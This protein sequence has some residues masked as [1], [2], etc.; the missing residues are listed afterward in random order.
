M[1]YLKVKQAPCVI[2]DSFIADNDVF[3]LFDT[4]INI[5]FLDAFIDNITKF[6][7]IF[8]RFSMPNNIFFSCKANKSLAFLKFATKNGC[9]IE[10]SSYY[11]LID[12]LKYTNKIIASGPAKNV[13]YLN[14]AINNEVAISVDDIKELEEIIKLNSEV[15]VLLRISD[16]LNITSRFGIG[17]S[18]IDAC[19]KLIKNS[20]IKLLGFSFHINGYNLDDRVSAIIKLL[21]IIKD[22]DLEIKYIDIGGG[23]PVNYCSK[24][25]YDN[26]IKNNNER[27][28]FKNRKIS[29]FYPY[30]SETA[31]EQ[32]LSYILE[33]VN[34][35]LDGIEI[36]V[37]PGRSLLNNCG[38][39]IYKV[40]YLK[41]LPSGDN[42]VVTNGNINCLSEQWFNTDYL[43]EPELF[44]REKTKKLS[45]P[46]FASVA[47][48]L[49][50]EQDM[51]T[52]RKIKFDYLPENGDYLIYY[53][54]AGYQMDSNES[55][56]H[57]IPLVQ[58]MVVK[59]AGKG[60]KI[61]KDADYDCK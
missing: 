61:K 45:L 8:E 27:L 5:L 19:L 51:L 4:P 37:E 58:K 9:G 60:Y 50:L 28:Y 52:W 44:K 21:T 46:I 41:N 40:E 20:K 38:I 55:T 11:E 25:D 18:Q 3:S 33:K 57:K 35:K 29:S 36:I 23:L 24:R 32:A 16:L 22:K 12:A 49:C 17:I 1:S 54:T 30:Y 34:N 14:L 26:F 53:N 31:G 47:G 7:N 56:F 59:K 42:L 2:V 15:A 43:I 13:E 48:N 39:S 10:V 6:K